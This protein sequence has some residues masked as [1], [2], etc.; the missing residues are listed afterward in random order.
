MSYN[1]PLPPPCIKVSISNPLPV[2]GFDNLYTC[3]LSI[4]PQP[5]QGGGS[6]YD[7]LNIVPGFW[8]SNY[9]FGEAWRINQTSN[10]NVGAQTMDAVIEDVEYYNYSIDPDTGEHGPNDGG[11]G[12]CWTL[13]D[14]GLPNL[15]P[16][17]PTF[18]TTTGN[19]TY[20]TDLINR[21]RSRN[22]Y[23]SYVQAYQNGST[24]QTGQ[25]LTM[26]STGSFQVAS[27]SSTDVYNTIAV[28]TSSGYPSSGYFTYRPFGEFL[29]YD[30]ITPPLTAGVGSVYYINS[31]G[32]IST[33]AGAN[34]YPV[35]IQVFLLVQVMVII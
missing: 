16:V 11:A 17:D 13:A 18:I 22:Y 29:T 14:D 30:R 23:T 20:V 6:Q 4:T 12:Y 34:S 26:S 5:I 1:A 21:F 19:Y 31:T 2:I 35:Y 25:F 24:F 32:G 15:F 3:T 10:I 7:V 27:S 8:V 9:P 33:T 28:V